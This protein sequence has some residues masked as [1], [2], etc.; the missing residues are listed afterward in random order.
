MKKEMWGEKWL[1]AR[2]EL[3]AAMIGSHGQYVKMFCVTLRAK[4]IKN[5]TEIVRIY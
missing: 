4:H 3:Q 2:K 5:C 1:P